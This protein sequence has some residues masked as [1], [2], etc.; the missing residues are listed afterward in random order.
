MEH[1]SLQELI[2]ILEHAHQFHIAVTF[3]ERCGNEKTRVPA[4]QRIHNR[5]ICDTA[6][7]DTE[8]YSRCYRC[9]E[10]VMRMATTRKKSF[11]GLCANG[12]YEYCR[13]IVRDGWVVGVILIGNIYNGSPEQLRRLEKSGLLH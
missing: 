11:G 8:G 6:K 12:V 4:E 7:A 13:P 10:M 2:R 5:P 9:Q 3:F 1:S